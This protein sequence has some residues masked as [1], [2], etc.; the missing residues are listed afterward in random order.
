MEKLLLAA[1]I[2]L[3]G[4]F[5]SGLVF[6]LLAGFLLCVVFGASD[7]LLFLAILC[8]AEVGGLC[9]GVMA[10]KWMYGAIR[11]GHMLIAAL[12]SIVGCFLAF[13][14][15]KELIARASAGFH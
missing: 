4:A 2:V 10:E 5:A 12:L 1:A 13:N 7:D 8:F 9:S 6:G 3:F 14:F 15:A 11:Q